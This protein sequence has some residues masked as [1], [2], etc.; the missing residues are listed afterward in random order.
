M[1]RYRQ[2]LG[3]EMEDG[4]PFADELG[5]EGDFTDQQLDVPGEPFPQLEQETDRDPEELIKVLGNHPYLDW[6]IP[7]EEEIS[8]NNIL[9]ASDEALDDL[10]DEINRRIVSLQTENKPGLSDDETEH[11]QSLKFLDD[12]QDFVHAIKDASK[13]D[14]EGIPSEE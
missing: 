12:L 4:D 5:G 8:P 3:E 14:S 10:L 13:E 2:I 1:V 9:G 11:G 7:E 6:D